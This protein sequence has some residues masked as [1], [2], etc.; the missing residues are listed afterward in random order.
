MSHKHRD[1]C[2]LSSELSKHFFYNPYHK[3]M[4]SVCELYQI[5]ILAQIIDR[6]CVHSHF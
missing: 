6:E 2:W 1:I 3:L 5:H 4:I